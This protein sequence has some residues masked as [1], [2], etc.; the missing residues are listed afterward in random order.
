MHPTLVFADH[1]WPPAAMA[2]L[3]DRISGG[4]RALGVGEGDTAAVM[5]RNGPAYVA[6]TIACR[7]AGVY[8]VS[9]NWHFKAAE[10]GFLL[11]DSGARVLLVH[12]DLQAQIA[13]GVPE[14]V[15]VQAVP[16]DETR[17]SDWAGAFA[18][19]QA[20]L[21]PATGVAF[22]TVV[23]TSGTTGRPKGV[24]RLPVPAGERA[25]LEAAGQ[26]VGR[27]VYGVTAASRALLSAPMYHS[28]TMSFVLSCCS[29]GAT[30]VLEPGFAAERTLALIEQHRITHAY[31]VPTMY[32][33]L[34]A[35]PEAV[36]SRHDLSSLQ[37]VS[38]TGSP[39]A[40]DLK[41]RMID[42]FGPVITEAYGSSEAGYT[43][44][45]DS[46]SWL[47]RPGSAGRAL[48]AAQVRILDEAGAPV[49][50]GQMGLI[51]VRQPATPD[52]TYIG[53]DEARAAIGRDGLVTLGDMGYLDAEGYLFIC[54]RKSDMVISGGV[55]IYPAEIEA[56]LVTMPGVADAAVFGIPDAEFGE[57]LAAAV[58]LR[59]GAVLDAAAVQ[60]WLRERLA[61]YKVPRTI[62]FHDSLPREDT[63]KIF[64]RRL[65]EPYW[66]GAARRI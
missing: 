13:G 5:L 33:R 30:L 21:P 56:E 19:G 37:Q 58:Q 18:L 52:F 45:I 66:E 62:A 2:E 29:A 39:C 57:G 35:L 59:P 42:W 22:N 16:H 12:D 49:P 63:G 20:P 31:L 27:T 8:L 24:R 55:N 34:L 60:A 47:Q 14:G 6:T 7:R 54:D 48:G 61:N 51:Y 17:G 25:A 10:A 36:R 44:F 4:L 1:S 32:Q 15:A 40:P 28:A 65:R 23:Y 38:S 26:Q 50:A 41:R 64:K 43:T 46:A 9:I 3:A 11:A 53:R